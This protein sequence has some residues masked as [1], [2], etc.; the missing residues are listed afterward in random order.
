MINH[1]KITGFD[2][3]KYDVFIQ[4]FDKIWIEINCTNII[5]E[6]NIFGKMIIDFANANNVYF[7]EEYANKLC[8]YC[9]NFDIEKILI[10]LNEYNNIKVKLFEIIE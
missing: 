7:L 1:S 9:E 6:I 8:H 5:S 3:L 10:Q 2:I 4:K